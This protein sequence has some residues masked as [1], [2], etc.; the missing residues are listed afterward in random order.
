MPHSRGGTPPHCLR[1]SQWI[2]HCNYT[3]VI[4]QTPV[5]LDYR[6]TV[7]GPA[8][9]PVGVNILSSWFQLLQ[10]SQYNLDP[11]RNYQWGSGERSFRRPAAGLSTRISSVVNCFAP[12][13]MEHVEQC[14]MPGELTI[15]FKPCLHKVERL[16]ELRRKKGEEDTKATREALSGINTF[17]LF[18]IDKLDALPIAT[19]IKQFV[20]RTKNLSPN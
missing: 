1:K 16:M 2:L 4:Y 17:E 6:R 14:A 3:Y 7:K 10:Q 20:M 9:S 13:E 8:L 15:H 18:A 5:S 12:C 19:L 11:R